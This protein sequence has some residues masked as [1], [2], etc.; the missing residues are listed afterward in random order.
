MSFFGLIRICSVK[1][2]AVIVQRLYETKIE[3]LEYSIL[4]KHQYAMSDMIT[5]DYIVR[6]PAGVRLH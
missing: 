6:L 3:N 1:Y 5:A 2:R 4:R